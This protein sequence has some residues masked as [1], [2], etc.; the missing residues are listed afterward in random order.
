MT[1]DARNTTDAA[2]LAVGAGRLAPMLNVSVR[3][4]RSLDAAGKLPAPIRLN[5][6]VRWIVSEIEDWLAAGAPSRAE[7]EARQTQ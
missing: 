2:A 5:G 1:T 3:T 7:W 4:V 6:A